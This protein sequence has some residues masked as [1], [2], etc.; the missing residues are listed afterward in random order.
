MR[1]NSVRG[2]PES[3]L[4]KQHTKK[5]WNLE[6]QPSD[7][8]LGLNRKRWQRFLGKNHFLA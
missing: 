2:K 3:Q 8:L 1:P 4:E 7:W 6:G 5:N